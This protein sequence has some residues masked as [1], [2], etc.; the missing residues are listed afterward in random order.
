MSDRLRKP[1]MW[2]ILRYAR[3]AHPGVFRVMQHSP[4]S[5]RSWCRP[6]ETG[7]KALDSGLCSDGP[8]I[9]LSPATVITIQGKPFLMRTARH[10]GCTTIE[11]SFP[12]GSH[13]RKGNSNIVGVKQALR[14]HSR[15][16]PTARP[17]RSICRSR[18]GR[19]RTN[20]TWGAANVAEVTA[21]ASRDLL[22]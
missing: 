3:H 4:L 16:I 8:A 6:V 10:W 9:P 1:G 15:Y 18:R 13:F 12:R 7:R 19:V 14:R 22:A 5:V 21:S 11:L 17:T 20:E 2:W